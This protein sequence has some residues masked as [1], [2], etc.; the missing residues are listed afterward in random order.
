M[1][2]SLLLSGREW[3]TPDLEEEKS[4]K[5]VMKGMERLGGKFITHSL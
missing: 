2:Q 1:V 5:G 4:R 3:S